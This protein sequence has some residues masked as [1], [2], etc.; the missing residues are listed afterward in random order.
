MQAQRA[1]EWI[2]KTHLLTPRAGNFHSVAHLD[3]KSVVI[4]A[5]KREIRF[6]GFPLPAGKIGAFDR[7]A[8]DGARSF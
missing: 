1:G 5:S 7:L 4:L 6:L 3:L 2:S 8:S